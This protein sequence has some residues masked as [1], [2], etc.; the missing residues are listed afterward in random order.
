MLNLQIVCTM[1]SSLKTAHMLR[2]GRRRCIQ[3][4]LDFQQCFKEAPKTHAISAGFQWLLNSFNHHIPWKPEDY[5]LYVIHLIVLIPGSNI[6]VLVR[7]RNQNIQGT[8]LCVGSL[9]LPGA[10]CTVVYGKTSDCPDQL[11][12]WETSSYRRLQIHSHK[13][14]RNKNGHM[15]LIQ[16]T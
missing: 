9:G 3:C 5:Y 16:T 10:F 7:V 15:I 12:A 13:T 8:V 6:H 2:R 11:I 1:L 14:N 4:I